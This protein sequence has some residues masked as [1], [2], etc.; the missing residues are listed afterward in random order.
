MGF[1][2]EIACLN[3]RCK[4]SGYGCNVAID[5][6]WAYPRFES[7]GSVVSNHFFIDLICARVLEALVD[8]LYFIMR[9]SGR[10]HHLPF[11]LVPEF[12]EL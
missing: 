12:S 11:H 8:S 2:V 1:I 10:F 4:N 3:E 6:F 5:S 7:S 9:T